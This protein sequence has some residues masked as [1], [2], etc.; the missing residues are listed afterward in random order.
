MAWMAG[1]VVVVEYVFSF[2]G[3]GAALV[4]AVA[5]RDMPVV[6]TVTMLAAAVYVVL[7][8]LADLATI[9]VTPRLRTAAR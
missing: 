7:N 2:P 8:L 3:I 5:N 1:G 4:G 9:L 6:Q